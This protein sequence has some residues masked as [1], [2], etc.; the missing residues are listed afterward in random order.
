MKDIY[1]TNTVLFWVRD[2]ISHV[3]GKYIEYLQDDAH[4][5]IRESE[6]EVIQKVFQ[7][8]QQWLYHTTMDTV[9]K[10]TRD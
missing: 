5:P 4:E 7:D 1:Y 6:L 10:R 9:N 8:F 3:I 2:F